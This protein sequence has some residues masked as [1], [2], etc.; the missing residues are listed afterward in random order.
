MSCVGRAPASAKWMQRGGPPNWRSAQAPRCVRGGRPTGC[1]WG[2]GRPPGGRPAGRTSRRGLWVS[3]TESA[4]RRDPAGWGAPP[5]AGSRLGRS[6]AGIFGP[7]HR[8]GRLLARRPAAGR[9][10]AGRRAPTATAAR[11]RKPNHRGRM[12]GPARRPQ[13]RH[14]RRDGRR[15][16]HDRATAALYDRGS[17]WCRSGP[18]LPAVPPAGIRSTL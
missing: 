9:P 14:G 13:A 3:H 10:T 5:G 8:S 16:R 18:P 11:G 17:A 4:P 1:A 6:A 15:S 2:C 12:C 7:G